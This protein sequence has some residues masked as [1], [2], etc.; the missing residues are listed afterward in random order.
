[1]KEYKCD[2]ISVFV[3]LLRCMQII[4]KGSLIT[5]LD[6]TSKMTV[7]IQINSVQILLY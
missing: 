5:I 6:S 4:T 7:I 1:M 2:D 3:I